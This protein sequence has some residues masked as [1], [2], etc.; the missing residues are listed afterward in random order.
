MF[1]NSVSLTITSIML[2]NDL[3]T[4]VRN[5]VVISGIFDSFREK[6]NVDQSTLHVTFQRAAIFIVT[7][8][9]KHSMHIIQPDNETESSSESLLSG[10]NIL[11]TGGARRIGE[12]I[13]RHLHMHGARLLVHYDTSHAE[14]L[15]LQEQLNNSRPESVEIIQGSFHQIAELKVNLRH[16]I[17]EFGG[18]DC[19]INNA[20]RFYPT[21]ISSTGDDQW[22]DLITTN[23]IAPYFLSQT[24]APYLRKRRG[25]I[26]NITDI[27]AE[28]PLS[29]YSV[30]SAS[31]AALMSLTRSL[32]L[33]LGPEIRV[34]GI[35]PGAILW[36][37]HDNDELV[38]QRII[39]KTALK[40]VGN[41]EDIARTALFFV[42]SA[43]YITGQIINVDG[44]RS[45]QH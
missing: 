9:T 22:D 6:L 18:L 8:K 35:A 29:G 20:S 15:A 33:E 16:A 26:I 27:Y 3:S 32:A 31:K 11:V 41:P 4:K 38:Q 12:A 5:S 10:K 40:Q 23:L 24:T 30:Y 39:A 37:E 44:G 13:T 17:H 14:A 36:P 28:R 21:P 1:V 45:I 42:S 19:L 2:P 7:K 43:D 34:N 25:S